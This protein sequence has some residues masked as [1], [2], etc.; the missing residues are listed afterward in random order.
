MDIKPITTIV[1]AF[2]SGF[3]SLSRNRI[4]ARF[5]DDIRNL[6]QK[7]PVPTYCLVLVPSHPVTR[8]TNVYKFRSQA[9][10][11]L[12]I[13]T[14]RKRHNLS[15]VVLTFERRL[16]FFKV[17]FDASTLRSEQLFNNALC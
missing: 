15:K 9:S 5:L 8:N 7:L 17:Y 3:T 1:R 2:V 10:P 4:L 6:T 12:K 16:D 13:Q 14:D 11:S